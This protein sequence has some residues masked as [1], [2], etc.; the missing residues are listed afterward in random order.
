LSRIAWSRYEGNDVEAVVA[1]FINRERPNSVRI[2]PSVGDGGVDILDR[3]GASDGSDLVFQVKRYTSPLKK[4]QKDEI[5]ESLDRL[6]SDPR[7]VA[8][9]VWWRLLTSRKD[10]EHAEVEEVSVG[11]EGPSGAAGSGRA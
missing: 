3:G 2:T 1:M 9:Q 10:V 11:V 6:L 8:P 5:E 4:K 7:C